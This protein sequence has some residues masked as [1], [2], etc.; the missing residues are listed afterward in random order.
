MS[1]SPRWTPP[2]ATRTTSTACSKPPSTPA[3]P[4]STFPTPWD[5]PRRR[6]S[7]SSSRASTRTSG[8]STR[9]S[10]R[11]TAITTLGSPWRI[12]SPAVRAGARQIECTVNGIGERA[13]NASLEEV[14]MAIRTRGD[15]YDLTTNVD[16]TNIV[17]ASRLVSEHTGFSVQ[18]NK[19]I[20][21]KNAF[22]HASGIH[23]DGILKDRFDLR[24]HE[25]ARDRPQHVAGA[26]QA[27]RAPR[28]PPTPGRT[29]LPPRRRRPQARLRTLPDRRREE[30]RDQRPRP[31]LTR[32]RRTAHDRRG[33]SPRPRA[34]LLRQPR[35]PH[36]DGAH[37]RPQR[38][39]VPGGGDRYGPGGCLLQGRRPDHR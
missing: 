4:R 32:L 24:D 9:P 14:V 1:S 20:V 36:G 12:A 39:G 13:G 3:R 30:E 25:P 26:G 8:I 29:R 11:C 2:A 6:S 21:G 28:L 16:T 17:R 10:S 15:T 37:H 22:R 34:G 33:L 38:R 19:A 7:T 23:Q 27:Q 18:P 5:T 31:H 35:D